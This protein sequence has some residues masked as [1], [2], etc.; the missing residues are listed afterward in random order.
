MYFDRSAQA[1]PTE[2][3]VAERQRVFAHISAR[4]KVAY[5][6]MAKTIETTRS[7]VAD[8]WALL[9]SIAAVLERKN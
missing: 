4:N 7:K 9:M 1:P 3:H 6:D 2:Q 8:L 5:N